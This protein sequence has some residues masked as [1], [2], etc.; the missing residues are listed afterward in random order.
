MKFALVAA[1]A[2]FA[3]APAF[4]QTASP[5]P[6]MSAADHAAMTAKTVKASG[7]VTGVDAKG[8]KI[9]LHHGPIPELKWPAMTMGFKA[10]ADVL[11]TAKVGQKVTFQLNPATSEV[12]ALQPQ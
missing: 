11:K 3:S 4:A 5:M 7:V 9:T 2:L 1:A 6:G 10:S 12:V 8:G